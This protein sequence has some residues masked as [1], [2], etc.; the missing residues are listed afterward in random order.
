ML[1]RSRF[2]L[3]RVNV[4]KFPTQFGPLAIVRILLL[5]NILPVKE[6]KLHV[7]KNLFQRC[8]LCRGYLISKLLINI[9]CLGSC[10]EQLQNVF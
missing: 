7:V 1:T 4:S 10:N 2:G 5:L 6:I 8:V 3:L 9:S